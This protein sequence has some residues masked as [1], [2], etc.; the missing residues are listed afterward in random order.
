MVEWI[1]ITIIAVVLICVCGK[2]YL[3]CRQLK[4]EEDMDRIKWIQ[5]MQMEEKR[6][7]LLADK[8]WY[9]NK[10]EEIKTELEELKK[11]I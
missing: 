8:A 4:H 1:C 7:A 11:T 2:Y 6:A 5:K 10:L 3:Q 9:E